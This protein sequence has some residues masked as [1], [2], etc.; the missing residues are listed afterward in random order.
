MKIVLTAYK[1]RTT[2]CE[3]QSRS[4]TPTTN[5]NSRV[6]DDPFE[7]SASNYENNEP[8]TRVQVGISQDSSPVFAILAQNNVISERARLQ[9][10]PENEIESRID[11]IVVRLEAV[12]QITDEEYVQK[13]EA[14]LG[15]EGG[16]A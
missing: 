11:V 5:H 16:E 4:N 2:I 14:V 13:S 6:K 7:S 3:I 10:R 9:V 12:D 1:F 8:I 15:K